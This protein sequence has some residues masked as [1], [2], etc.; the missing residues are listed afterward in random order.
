VADNYERIVRWYLRFN[1][2]F[3]IENFYVHN[4]QRVYKEHVGDDTETDILGIRM[5]YSDEIAGTVKIANHG[6]LV[7][8][9]NGCF[10]VVIA[11]V[12]NAEDARPNSIW[13][14]PEDADAV[15]T[16]SYILK[17]IGGWNEKCLEEISR[18]LIADFRFCNERFRVRYIMFSKSLSKG[19]ANR[20]QHISFPE[21]VRF[22]DEQRGQC[23][24]EH[25]LGVAST[26][27]E[28]EPLI[29]EAFNAFNSERAPEERQSMVL[30]LL[31]D[32]GK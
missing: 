31:D 19:Y 3:T 16:V 23:W 8:G 28:W 6:P 10:D 11:E 24:K 29:N 13:R 17:F 5:P 2:Y 25:G 26:H 27:K 18:R 15:A 1:G 14:H 7:S 30:R 32:F 21:I 9:A 12:K 20:I 4:P 22:L